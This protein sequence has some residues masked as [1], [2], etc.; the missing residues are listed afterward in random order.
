MKR[1]FTLYRVSTKG[2]VD[3]DDIPMQKTACQEFAKSQ[4]DWL[5]TGEYYEKGVSGFKVSAEERDAIQDIKSAAEKKEFD[6]LLVF[7]FDRLGRRQNET[8]FVVEWFVNQ[9]IEVWSAKEGQQ[10]F[11]NE[12]DYLINFMRFWQAGGESRKTSM[13]V[14]T[15]LE[16]LTEE[17]VYTGGV[18]PLGYELVK[19][20]RHNK[21]GK[22]LS[23]IS[24]NE[25]MANYVRLI[26]E[27]T[28]KNGY[29][30]YRM[31]EYLNRLGVKTANGSKFQCNTINRILK[32]KLYCGYIHNGDACS[33]KLHYLEI[34]DENLF[35]QAQ[36]IIEQRSHKEDE[37]RHIAQNTKGKTLL[38]GN[39]FCAS[40]G[41]RMNATSYIDKYKRKDGSM[42][43]VRKQ[44]YICTG[45]TKNNT[46]CQGQVAYVGTKIDETVSEIVCEYLGKIKTTPKSIA[47]E[48]RYQRE[49]SI[50]KTARKKLATET[51]KLRKRLKGLTDEISKSLMGESTFSPE[52][53]SEAIESA[54]EQIRE[55]DQ[56]LTDMEMKILDGELMTKKLDHYYTQF[57]TWSDEFSEASNEQKK[58]IICQLISRIE[59]GRG[60]ELN[61]EFNTDYEQFF[62]M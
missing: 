49:I 7:M 55:N 21:K 27:M 48:R 16:Q 29:G 57:K 44:R 4:G 5:I 28:V 45:K 11:D 52:M 19:S 60:Y 31:A 24:I 40:C 15:R 56:K 30:S 25:E 50:S 1:V 58:M 14:K 39:I 26:F 38:S 35:N 6:I 33:E 10:R 2:Q 9:G 61:I 36:E 22:E 32:N 51:D 46:S 41:A 18:I 62:M 23:D 47:L 3:Q 43:E 37:K 53:L 12:A 8:P 20:G 34:I 42:Y 59:F 17:G 54:K 13:R